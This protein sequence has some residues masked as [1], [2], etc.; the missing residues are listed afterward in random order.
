[1]CHVQQKLLE[2]SKSSLN[3]LHPKFGSV[4]FVCAASEKASV[5]RQ[6]L[7]RVQ[8]EEKPIGVR[9]KKKQN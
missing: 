3:V 2:Y 9:V 5:H 6:I 1:M 7:G 4:N 8:Y